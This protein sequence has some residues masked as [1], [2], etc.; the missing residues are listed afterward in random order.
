MFTLKQVLPLSMTLEKNK[1]FS[2]VAKKRKTSEAYRNDLHRL[3]LSS[4]VLPGVACHSCIQ[5]AL[6]ARKCSAHLFFSIRGTLHCHLP[7]SNK[8]SAGQSLL[9]TC[10]RKT[11][12]SVFQWLLA[13]TRTRVVLSVHTPCVRPQCTCSSLESN[14]KS[15]IVR[16]DTNYSVFFLFWVVFLETNYSKWVTLL[17]YW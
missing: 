11:S 3:I 2:L 14:A 15:G 10:G 13:E 17:Q 6:V 16:K 7:F 4:F 1:T 8:R 12:S 9:H 5:P